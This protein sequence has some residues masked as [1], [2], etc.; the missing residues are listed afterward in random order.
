MPA[1]IIFTMQ[2][3]KISRLDFFGQVDIA[4]FRCERGRDR[5]DGDG[6]DRDLAGEHHDAEP[7]RGRPVDH[8]ADD[9]ACCRRL[10]RLDFQWGS[11]DGS[12]GASAGAGSAGK[13]QPASIQSAAILTRQIPFMRR[14]RN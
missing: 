3:G 1:C 7:E 11:S 4:H 10:Q 14:N 2:D 8:D 12:G 9:G 13:G 5:D 6:R